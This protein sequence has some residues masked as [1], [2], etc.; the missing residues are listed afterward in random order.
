MEQDPEKP[1]RNRD[2]DVPARKGDTIEPTA[3][4]ERS[5][6]KREGNAPLPEEET[7][8]R[9]SEERTAGPLSDRCVKRA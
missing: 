6:S 8:E 9:E 1:P 5:P 3:I 7:Y 2:Q 4:P